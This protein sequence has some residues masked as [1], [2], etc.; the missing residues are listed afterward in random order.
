MEK[1]ASSEAPLYL[2]I[3]RLIE[4]HIR[5]GVLRV[6][7]RIPSVRSLSRKRKVSISTVL[8]AY[9][10]L[11]NR[12]YV[13]A[14]NKSGFYVRVPATD[15]I[16]EPKVQNSDPAP[17]EVGVGEILMKI[18]RAVSD[19]AKVPL[20][21]ACPGPTLLP[22]H[23]LN[24]ITRLIA[25]KDPLHSSNYQFP[26]GSELLRRQIARRSLDFGCSFSAAD[27]VITCGAMEALNL[28]LRAVAKPGDVVAVES[29]TYFGMLQAVESLGMRALEIPT[30]PRT[31]MDLD[32]LDR[33]IKK[34]DVKA[35]IVMMNCH[36][37]LGYV[38]G[39][40]SKKA[41]V[42]LMAKHQVPLIEDDLYGDLAFDLRR[43]K[44]AKAF[45]RAGLVLLC[46]SF[47]KV[48][49]AGFRVG[50]VEPGRFRQEVERL[51]FV[52]TIATPSL[53]Q[54]VVANFLESGGYDRYLR[55]LRLAFSEQVQTMSQA[56]AKYFPSGSRLTRPWGGYLLW[57]ELP[58]RVS[59]LTLFRQ[60]L[61]ENITILP[62]PVFSASGH[63]KNHIRISCGYPW[64]DELDRALLTL[65]K[66]CERAD[67][68]PR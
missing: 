23:K 63:F 2:Q 67:S 16:P 60:A 21:G 33:S 12:G 49:A 51:K 3:A 25:Q 64:S 32:I 48:L 38:L 7:D 56:I 9:F 65:G 35:C 57:V 61:A 41:L 1:A 44:V 58:K 29:P 40:Q 46:S 10:W 59:A 54:L 28:C 6:G 26:P 15:L 30:H 68:R 22:H 18:L 37:P 45:D 17:A 5:D 62:G 20:G 53:P 4:K 11:E 42:E 34:H 19:P 66:L 36:N 24:Q 50:W 14:R 39:D 31:G 55:R 27:I 13:E 52:S 8:E 43:P 47:S